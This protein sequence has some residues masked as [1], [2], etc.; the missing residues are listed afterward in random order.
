M[1]DNTFAG[2]R[3]GRLAVCEIREVR[4]KSTTAL[5]KAFLDYTTGGLNSYASMQFI[6]DR[7]TAAVFDIFDITSVFH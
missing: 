7:G 6:G 4:W 5:C 3:N 1:S 2:S